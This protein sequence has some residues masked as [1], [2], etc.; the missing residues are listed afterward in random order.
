[1]ELLHWPGGRALAH[2]TGHV[3]A[4]LLWGSLVVLAVIGIAIFVGL[5]GMVLWGIFIGPPE[6]TP[7]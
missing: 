7:G 4:L 1:M 3:T 5:L 2:G 6:I